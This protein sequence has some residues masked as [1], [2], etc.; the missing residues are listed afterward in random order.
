MNIVSVKNVS[1]QQDYLLKEDNK[2]VL[3]LRYKKDLHSARI[4]TESERR[5]LIIDDEG[6]LRT[7]LIL[8]NEYGIRIGS[9]VYDNFSDVHGSVE[10]ENTR[11]RFFVQNGSELQI[12]KG[13]RRNLI[14]S[15]Q[16]SFDDDSSKEPR[17]QLSSLIIS[18]SW[19]L[20]LKDIGKGKQKSVFN[21]AIIL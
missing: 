16:L 8:K 15:C 11:Y 21:E 19:Y 17:S 20:F 2:T 14:Y 3:K 6:L 12:Y 5:V 18:V 13:S 7:R 1:G 10:I 9:L 4:E